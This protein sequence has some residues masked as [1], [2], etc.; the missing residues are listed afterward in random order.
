VRI[1]LKVTPAGSWVGGEARAA[2]QSIVANGARLMGVQWIETALNTAYFA[3]MARCLGPSLYG[4]WAYGIAAYVLVI[5]F[6]GFGL[7]ALVFL[8]V[9]RD[10]RIAGDFVGMMLTLRLTLLGVGAIALAAYAFAAEPDRLSRL[11][12]LLLVP[13]LF[14]RGLALTARVCFLAYERMAD[15]AKFVAL[16]RS[17]EAVCGIAYLLAGGGL[18][19]VVVLHVLWWIA[20]GA[21]GLLRIRSRL[22]RYA[23]R[24]AWRPMGG[25]LAEGTV[26]GLGTAANTC[27]SSG[28]ILI[29]G[30]TTV[31]MAQLGQFAIVLSLTMILTGSAQAFFTAAL[32]VLSRST[33]GADTGIAYGRIAALAIAVGAVLTAIVA[34]TA[35]PPVAQWALGA[36]YAEAGGLLAP[37]VLIGGTILVPT[38]YAQM[39]LVAGRRWPL[40]LAEVAAALCLAAALAPAV[41][42][43]GLN[44]AVLATGGSWLLRAVILVGCGEAD[45]ARAFRQAAGLGGPV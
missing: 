41:A 2:A 33:P 7:D 29:L 16:F 18:I 12:L 38:G 19:G 40:A 26:L 37:F 24:F 4:H 45:G 42:V 9:G 5:G 6:L 20:E 17:A 36:R 44:G 14:G 43:W 39:L 28:P 11:V 34:W 35:G 3:V 31:G 23:L 21:F 30:H 22:T 32:P 15:Y 10:K 25:L 13:A 8:R 1:S 27:L